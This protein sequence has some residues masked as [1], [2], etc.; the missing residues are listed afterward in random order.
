MVRELTGHEAD[1]SSLAW[2]PDGDRLASGSQD[3]TCR[4]WDPA[5]GASVRQLK[6][7]AH[8][9]TAAVSGVAW[10]PDG[11][12]L[13][14]ASGALKLP[15]TDETVNLVR[16][17]DAGTGRAEPGGMDVQPPRAEWGGDYSGMIDALQS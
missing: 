10:S 12:T 17:F 14:A 2:S 16:F 11:R 4:L 7:E 6:I 3:R 15:E 13:A 1:V 8:G 9:E 5:T